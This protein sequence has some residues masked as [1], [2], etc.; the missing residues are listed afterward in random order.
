FEGGYGGLAGVNNQVATV[1]E[2]IAEVNAQA[3]KGVDIIK[4][5]MD[6]E[7]GTMPKMP[8]EMSQAIIDTAH[9][10]GLRVTAHV[11]YLDDAKELVDQGVDA[12][13]H[14]VRDQLIDQELIDAMKENGVWQQAET[15]SREASMFAYGETP[16]FLDDPFFRR[17]VSEETLEQ[18]ADPE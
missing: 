11:F 10:R 18:L 15:L 8:Y 9:E 6:D 1:D 14:A 5:W 12:F 4:F 17:S 2:A 13:A 3:D 7:L 16:P